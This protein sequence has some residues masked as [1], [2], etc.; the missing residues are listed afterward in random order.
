VFALEGFFPPRAHLVQAHEAAAVA[1]QGLF[2]LGPE[3]AFTQA[4]GDAEVHA[5]IGDG[6]TDRAAPHLGREFFGR[7]Q[8][9]RGRIEQRGVGAAWVEGRGAR[10]WCRPGRRTMVGLQGD[11]RRPGEAQVAAPGGTG[12]EVFLQGERAEEAALHAVQDGGE[13]VC[14][15]DSGGGGEFRGGCAGGGGRGEVAGVGD[16]GGED[17]ENSPDAPRDGA[18][19]CGRGGGWGC[20]GH[21]FGGSR[22]FRTK[23]EYYDFGPNTWVCWMGRW[24]QIEMPA[25]EPSG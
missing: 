21:G 19:F 3:C 11:A 4:G 16:E 12:E 14:A 24:K 9:G 5:D 15:E 1:P 25:F 7:G 8:A 22:F 23:Q 10:A 2:H 20:S 6:A 17:G 13:M 18:G